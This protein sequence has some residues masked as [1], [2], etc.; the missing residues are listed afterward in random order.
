M[1]N[2]LCPCLF[3]EDKAE[4]REKPRYHTMLEEIEELEQAVARR[5]RKQSLCC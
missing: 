3:R 5:L 1:G 4:E 2:A